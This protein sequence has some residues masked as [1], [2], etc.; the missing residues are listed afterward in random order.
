MGLKMPRDTIKH[1]SGSP[2]KESF[3]S[4][5]QL[6]T[7]CCFLFHHFPFHPF[8]CATL[9]CLSLVFVQAH[10]TI[11]GNDVSVW[12][13]TLTTHDAI[14][15]YTI[16]IQYIHDSFFFLG[17]HA[18]LSV[19]AI[20]GQL[21]NPISLFSLVSFTVKTEC[22]RISHTA[23]NG[24]KD[25]EKGIQWIFRDGERVFFPE[26]QVHQIRSRCVSCVSVAG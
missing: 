6:G 9:S 24:H 7:C 21:H 14:R 4:P 19:Q 18:T 16:Y 11:W 10:C 8:K 15:L 12:S 23:A 5:F 17:F 26:T 2:L 20:F 22:N 13:Q 1:Q 3:V 25:G